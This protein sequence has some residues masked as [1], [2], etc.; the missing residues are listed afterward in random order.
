L[1]Y[2]YDYIILMNMLN[3]FYAGIHFNCE[4]MN[5]C[6]K[7]LH[8]EVCIIFKKN[9]DQYKYILY[10]FIEIFILNYVIPTLFWT[11]STYPT[12]LDVALLRINAIYGTSFFLYYLCGLA[13]GNKKTMSNQ[14]YLS[15]QSS[16]RV[17]I[18]MQHT[19]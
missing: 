10:C 16:V 19:W 17:K 7:A 12:F 9:Q 11:I 6:K 18:K 13:L 5:S 8:Y 3:F 1:N 2:V 14:N 15:N 4:I